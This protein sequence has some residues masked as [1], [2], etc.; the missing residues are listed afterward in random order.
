MD[1]RSVLAVC[2]F[3]LAT[4]GAVARGDALPPAGGTLS[5]VVT[6]SQSLPDDRYLHGGEYSCGV[7][8]AA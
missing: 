7:E 4:M 1:C 6:W 3:W 8:L 2:S 5:G